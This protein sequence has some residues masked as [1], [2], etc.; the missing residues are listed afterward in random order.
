MWSRGRRWRRSPAQRIARIARAG[1]R[2]SGEAD[3]MIGMMQPLM[4][5]LFGTFREPPESIQCFFHFFFLKWGFSR[6]NHEWDVSDGNFHSHGG[7]PEIPNLKW[8]NKGS[9][10]SGNLHIVLVVMDYNHPM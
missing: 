1:E 8:M 6:T 4:M 7:Y 5:D 10:I 9:P 3:G 2:R